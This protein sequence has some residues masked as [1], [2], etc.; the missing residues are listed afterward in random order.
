MSDVAYLNS[1]PFQ[2]AYLYHDHQGC[3][4]GRNKSLEVYCIVLNTHLSRIR[5]GRR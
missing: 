1:L 5:F 3:E 4:L 2:P